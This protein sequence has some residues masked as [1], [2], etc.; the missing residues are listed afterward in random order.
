M[1]IKIN[2]IFSTFDHTILSFYHSLAL[3]YD[4]ILNPIASVLEKIGDM[5]YLLIAWFALF[6]FLFTKKKKEGLLLAC[7]ILVAFVA[8]EV[9]KVIVKRPRPFIELKEYYD[10]WVFVGSH[11]T[12]EFCFPSGHAIGAF[13]ALTAWFINSKNKKVNWLVFIYAIV[14]AASRNYLIAHYPSDV[15]VGSILGIISGIIAYYIVELFY[16]IIKKIP[17]FFVSRFVLEGKLRKQGK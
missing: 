7:G 17:N 1:Y 10:W 3:K 9:I 11:D 6:L 8:C 2:E 12:S 4:A 14:M 5:P 16:F 13:G 15:L